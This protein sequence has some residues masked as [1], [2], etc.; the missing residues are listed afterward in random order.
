MGAMACAHAP[1]ARSPSIDPA[2]VGQLLP[3]RVRR[4]SSVEYERTV[5]ALLGVDLPIAGRKRQVVVHF[6]KNGF[7][8]TIDRKTGEVV[9]AKPFSYVT[10][11]TG[12]DTATGSPLRSVIMPREVGIGISRTKRASPWRW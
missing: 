12:V 5:H 9:V 10:W 6:N 1:A 4:L 8:Y 3:S 2:K 11:A 7:A